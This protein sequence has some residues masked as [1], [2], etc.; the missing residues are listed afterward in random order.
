MQIGDIVNFRDDITEQELLDAGLSEREIHDIPVSVIDLEESEYQG[1]VVT[2]VS[3][4][5]DIFQYPTSFFK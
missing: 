4:Q 1:Q 3:I 5:E 2:W